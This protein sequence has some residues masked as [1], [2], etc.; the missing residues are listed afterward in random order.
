MKT[1]I[2]Q[3][4]AVI[5]DQVRAKMLWT[6]L[7]GKACTATELAISAN[8]SPQNASMHL[9]KLLRADL[10]KVE[11]RGKYRYYRFS[12]QEVAYA[13]EALAGLV[14]RSNAGLDHHN[15]STSDIRYC[16]TCYDHLAGKMG[17]LITNALLEKDL[18]VRKRKTFDVTRKGVTW[19]SKLDIHP[20]GL[21]T[22]R[23]PFARPCLDWTERE[24]HLAGSLGASLLT[25]MLSSDWIR[26]VRF[27]RAII[28]TAK[29]RQHLSHEL[30]IE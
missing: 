28:F 17:V 21:K 9:S 8:A 25:A 23:R 20:L 30:G 29:G 5:G 11:H 2:E 14:S 15:G 22:Q 27:S 18:I 12:R 10:L 6:L 24:Y 19:F 3:I 26:R 16:R 4:A 1:D 7:D 13:I